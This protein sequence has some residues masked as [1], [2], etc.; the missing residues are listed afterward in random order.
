MGGLEE[1]VIRVMERFW[2]KSRPAAV[3]ARGHADATLAPGCDN[4][5]VTPAT[6]HLALAAERAGGGDGDTLFALHEILNAAR[7]RSA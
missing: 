7:G 6:L 2:A 4:L 1:A 5:A 3:E